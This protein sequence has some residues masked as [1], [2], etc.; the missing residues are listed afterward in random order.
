MLNEFT[1][2]HWEK[3]RFFSS[4]SMTTWAY[5]IAKKD[6][7]NDLN[8]TQLYSSGNGTTTDQQLVLSGWVNGGPTE[9][10]VNIENYRH[11]TWNHFCWKYST[12]MKDNKF[13][14]NGVF[15]GSVSM[16]EALPIPI[17]DDSKVTSIVLGQ[18]P[19]VF[20]G[21]FSATQLLNGEIS[22]LNFWDTILSDEKI[23]AIA[24]CQSVEKGNVISWE[25]KFVTNHGAEI[26]EI[27]DSDTF[28]VEEE[29]FI[30]FPKRQP[31]SIAK[32]LC[33]SHGGQLIT[34]SSLQENDKMIDILKQHEE[35]CMEENPTNPAN[36]GKAAWLGLVK[37]NS[38]WYTL[39]AESQKS[40]LNFTN[41]GNQPPIF[42]DTDCSYAS[43]S[44]KWKFQP[45]ESCV[46]LELCTVCQIIGQPVF[47]INGLCSQ[48]VFDFNYYL[49][50]DEKHA[51]SHYEGYSVSNIIKINNSW[52][53]VSKR[54]NEDINAKIIYEFGN[55]Y[56]FPIGRQEW[57]T[58]DPKCGIK[59]EQMKEISM[60]KCKFGSQFTCDSG[61][62]IDLDKRC[63]QMKFK[64]EERSSRALVDKCL[65]QGLK[66]DASFFD[67]ESEQE[68]DEEKLAEIERENKLKQKEEE[69]KRKEAERQARKEATIAARKRRPK[70]QSR[71]KRSNRGYYS[72]DGV[73]EEDDNSGNSNDQSPV[74][75]SDSQHPEDLDNVLNDALNSFTPITSTVP[76][77]RGRP[78]IDSS[79]IEESSVHRRKRPKISQKRNKSQSSEKSS[80]TGK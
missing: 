78:S 59:R 41:W 23:S 43:E 19:D 58:F 16:T 52:K 65:S 32:D 57:N 29:T 22:E 70:G 72:S 66:F 28:C 77:K 9:Y 38:T 7:H 30:V 17:A 44:G 54:G 36:T 13:Y 12:I 2:C 5:C 10:S 3:I 42:G 64:K 49:A 55:D 45:S 56:S 39:N 34:P 69:K 50:I 4:D 6:Q 46:N 14:Y 48:N 79:T 8:C 74:N 67:H 20:N 61:N 40:V 71:K 60:S 75:A 25:E 62:C 35:I 27:F 21:E 33:T 80:S 37:E 24:K 63:N 26:I 11:R 1:A 15:I 47:T 18:D 31:I 51:I 73:S 53:F 76:K 68:E